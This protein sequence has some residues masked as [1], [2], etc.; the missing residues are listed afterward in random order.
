M[1]QT[2]VAKFQ[3]ILKIPT[4]E[5]WQAWCLFVALQQGE[6][7]AAH[8]VL[9]LTKSWMDSN[10]RG[11]MTKT[12]KAWSDEIHIQHMRQQSQ[13]GNNVTMAVFLASGRDEIVVGVR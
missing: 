2:G 13:F 4:R 7:R 10:S 1:Q 3:N 6:Q 12:F 5:V 11:L 8:Q 9:G